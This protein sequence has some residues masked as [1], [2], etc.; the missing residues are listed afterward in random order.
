MRYGFVLIGLLMSSPTMSAEQSLSCVLPQQAQA[1]SY[2]INPKTDRLPANAKAKTDYYKLAISWSPAFCNK[3]HRKV[4]RLKKEGKVHEAERVKSQ[5]QLQC[6]SNNQFKW[7]LHGLWGQSCQGR[8]LSA[9]KDWRDIAKHPRYCDGDLPQLS[10]NTLRPYLCSSPGEKLL[11]GEWEKH[12][13]CDFDNANAYFKQAQQLFQS[14]KMPDI[15]PNTRGFISQ[16]KKK[17]PQLADK[18]LQFNGRD[19]IYV[20]YDKL[21][22][23][24]SCPVKE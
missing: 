3:Q 11:Q 23:A 7:V 10:Y 9:C 22:Q 16:V 14:I 21:F 24:M 18:Y 5:S 13:A 12:G 20:C 8:S 17:N 15:S 2:D 6:F 19:E 1:Y 4:E